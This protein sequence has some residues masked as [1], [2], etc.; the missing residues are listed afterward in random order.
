MKYTI[1]CV[2]SILRLREKKTEGEE[3]KAQ[4]SKELMDLT[5]QCALLLLNSSPESLLLSGEN[6]A[7]EAIKIRIEVLSWLSDRMDQTRA[8][9]DPERLQAFFSH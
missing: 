7:L 1:D 2:I 3:G 8:E 6:D 5:L 4:P 9:N